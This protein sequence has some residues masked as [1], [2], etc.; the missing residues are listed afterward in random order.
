MKKKLAL[1]SLVLVC[2]MLLSA[3]GCEHEWIKADCENPKT[4]ELCGETEGEPKGHDWKD[5]TCDDP[6]TCAKCDATEGEALGHTWVD[7]TCAAPKTCSACG[8]TE[9]E[10]LAHTWLDATTEAPMTCTVCGAT[11]GDPI[12]VDERFTTAACQDLFGTWAGDVTLDA[13]QLTGEDLGGM[14][15]NI[16]VHMEMTFANDGTCHTVIAIDAE[17]FMKEM[18]TFTVELTYLSM[19]EQGY[20]REEADQLM[21][22]SV[23][24]DIPT[25]VEAALAEQDMTAQMEEMND[26]TF[27]VYYVA[28]GKLYIGESWD[29]MNEG[30]A[31]TL[32][33]D[34]LTVP[35]E[36]VVDVVLTRQ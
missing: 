28:D 21:L 16:T 29:D 11:E 2:V 30:E 35:V 25:Y 12:M 19:E 9:G 36:D 20:T 6:K 23:G 22:A 18:V 5:A 33:G 8:E 15:L 4:C 14:N 3:C 32:D 26:E 10:A 27:G 31:F 17:S 13:A 7:A 24:M 1:L 34:T